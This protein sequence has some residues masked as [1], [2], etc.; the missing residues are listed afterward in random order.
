[1]EAIKKDAKYYLQMK[2]IFC[3]YKCSECGTTYKGFR[4]RVW[5]GRILCD[6]CYT[7]K[8]ENPEH[9]Q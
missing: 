2:T 4:P 5:K 9:T 7:G 3:E 1:M 8:I 6:R